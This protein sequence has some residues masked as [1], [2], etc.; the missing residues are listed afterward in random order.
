M[1][2]EK[3]KRKPTD[4]EIIMLKNGELSDKQLRMLS[5]EGIHLENVDL[6][7]RCLDN[8]N[9]ESAHLKRLHFV[10]SSLKN[11]N[12]KNTYL[13][14]ND[15]ERAHLEG[16]NF[17]RAY[18]KV[19]DFSYTHFEESNFK[20]AILEH[21]QFQ[22]AHLIKTQFYNAHLKNVYFAWA[23]LDKT[24]FKNAQLKNIKFDE[25][26]LRSV[27]LSQSKMNYNP[28]EF[29]K[30]NFEFD[31][32]GIFAYKIFDLYETPPE[33]WKI[34]KN[35]VITENVNFIPTERCGCGINVTTLKRLVFNINSSIYRDIWL[36]HIDFVDL[37]NAIVPYTSTDSFRVGR[38]RLVR[39]LTAQEKEDEQ[40]KTDADRN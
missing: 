8:I 30:S 26:R 11:A 17:E 22:A 39:K 19:I 33:S 27:N 16:S 21:T 5:F 20:D 36:I 31:D 35:S 2:E 7:H 28:A 38:C 32:T 12:F 37:I 29:L 6:S 10:N 15:F 25:T 18:L 1:I 13:E 14:Y 4:S 34:K 40:R 9:F 24:N 23:T 3:E